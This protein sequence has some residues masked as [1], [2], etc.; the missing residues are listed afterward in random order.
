MLFRL[1]HPTPLIEGRLVARYDRFIAEVRLADGKTV[2]AH[3]VNPGR[4]EGVVEA[5]RRVWLRYVPSKTRKLAYTWE[6]VEDHDE[7]GKMVLTG[8]DTSAPNR[9]IG[10]ALSTRAIPGFRRYR[11]LRA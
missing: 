7:D 5:G 9:I 11:A 4:M 2:R 3:C 10:A 6:L 1:P 8:A